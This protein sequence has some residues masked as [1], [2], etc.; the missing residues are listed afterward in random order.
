MNNLLPSSVFPRAVNGTKMEPIGKIS[1]TFQLGNKQHTDEVHIYPNV[2]GLL[3]SWK[4]AKNLGILPECYPQP[5]IDTSTT[6]RIAG[7]PPSPNV[8][9]AVS[10]EYEPA[11]ITDPLMTEFPSIFDGQ[12]RSMEGEQFHMSLTDNATPFCVNTPIRIP[13]QTQI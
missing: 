5:M 7:D 6:P 1:L 11:S 8:F 4:A 3:I 2:F 13:R 10:T 12:V 9:A